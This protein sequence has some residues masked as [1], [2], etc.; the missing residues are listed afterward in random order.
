M[1]WIEINQTLKE[2]EQKLRMSESLFVDPTIK[3]CIL[4]L[5][6]LSD[7]IAQFKKT[8]SNERHQ[9]VD[10]NSVVRI[11][12]DSDSLK[13]HGLVEST[14]ESI[15]TKSPFIVV[16]VQTQSLKKRL[17]KVFQDYDITVNFLS[18]F[19]HSIQQTLFQSETLYLVED[20]VV[21]ANRSR[22]DKNGV[23]SE[24]TVVFCEELG[25][26]LSTHWQYCIAKN[27]QTSDILS[28][29]K[30]V[31]HAPISVSKKPATVEKTH[32]KSS[33]ISTLIDDCKESCTSQKVSELTG[34]VLQLIDESKSIQFSKGLSILE[35][36]IEMLGNEQFSLMLLKFEEFNQR[37]LFFDSE[38]AA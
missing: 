35:E 30:E 37:Y 34:H 4:S 16:V 12:S 15:L 28:L 29:M 25:Q 32:S 33:K 2:I 1:L 6:K 27:A 23:V 14:A 26:D 8:E 21:L 10:G 5:H 17:K 13:N 22:L 9:D 36:I 3:E 7:L 24:H 38:N 20:E 31:L 18:S 11:K 19:N